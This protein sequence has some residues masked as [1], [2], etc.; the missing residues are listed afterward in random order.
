MGECYCQRH[1]AGYPDDSE[2]SKKGSKKT[3]IRIVRKDQLSE[4]F[5]SYSI[6]SFLTRPDPGLMEL[7]RFSL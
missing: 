7:L 2:G 1:R 3:V 4:I 6:I 5:L